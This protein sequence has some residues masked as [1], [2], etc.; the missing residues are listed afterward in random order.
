[1][2][3][4]VS[5]SLNICFKT[6]TGNNESSLGMSPTKSTRDFREKELRRGLKED[7]VFAAKLGR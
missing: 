4:N 6:H 3:N 1:M 2:T 7:S 5:S